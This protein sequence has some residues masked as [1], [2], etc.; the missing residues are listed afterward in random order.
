M[1]FFDLEDFPERRILVSE[2]IR[3]LKRLLKWF[4]NQMRIK[5][6]RTS[7]LIAYDGSVQLAPKLD[8]VPP[9]KRG[10]EDLRVETSENIYNLESKEYLSNKFQKLDISDII[11]S[12]SL[13]GK[14]GVSCEVDQVISDS[15]ALNMIDFAHTFCDLEDMSSTLDD[16]YMFGLRSAIDHLEQCLSL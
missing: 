12:S 10:L 1:Q 11:E 2:M 8:D 13:K 5:F 6:F 4:E 3:R 14:T 15:V 16:N 7:L 9:M